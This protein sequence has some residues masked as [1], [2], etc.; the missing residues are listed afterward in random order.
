MCTFCRGQMVS[1]HR[2]LAFRQATAKGDVSCRVTI[3][4]EVCTRCGYT[5]WGEEAEAAIDAAVRR[6]HDKLSGAARSAPRQVQP[7]GEP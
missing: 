1:E 7:C 5:T 6:E 2:E 3:P 4:M